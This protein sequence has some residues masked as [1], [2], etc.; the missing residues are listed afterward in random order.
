MRDQ[1]FTRSYLLPKIQKRLQNVPVSPVISDS[2]YYIENISS[3]LDHHL[4]PLAQAVK[5]YIKGTNKFLK[6]LRSQPQLPDGFILCIRDVAE[7]YPNISLDEGLSA[8]RKR[9]KIRKEKYV[10]TGTIISLAEVVL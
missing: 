3:F 1:K 9:L 5:S 2:G 7:L 10:S 8:L 4:Q 6:K